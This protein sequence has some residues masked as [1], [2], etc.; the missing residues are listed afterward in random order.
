MAPP[1]TTPRRRAALLAVLVGA[2][3]VGLVGMHHLMAG[4]SVAPSSL[5]L[6]S[7]ASPAASPA[8]PTAAPDLG[9]GRHGPEQPAPPGHGDH[10]SS[11][12][13]LCLAVL[14]VVGAL[15]AVL[16]LWRGGRMPSRAPGGRSHRPRPAPRAPPPTSPERLALLCVLRT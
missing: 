15:A 2:L 4:P 9:S 5:A 7:V 13:H 1:T 8:A 10:E 12:L 16:L 6:P 11:L 3:F 14:T